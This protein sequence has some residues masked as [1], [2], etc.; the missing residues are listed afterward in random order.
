MDPNQISVEIMRENISLLE[1]I[2]AGD[3]STLA[4]VWLK[5]LHGRIESF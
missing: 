2:V 1:S 4:N 5:H 3:E